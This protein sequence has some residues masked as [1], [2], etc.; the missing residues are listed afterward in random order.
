MRIADDLKVHPS[1]KGIQPEMSSVFPVIDETYESLGY[2]AW[3]TSGTEGEHNPGSL[4]PKGLAT[5][6]RTNHMREDLVPILVARLKKNLGGVRSE[7]DVVVEDDHLH[8]E[9]DP[10]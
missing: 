6:W 10:E 7:Y 4:H 5:D 2:E 3:L 1:L 9:F 8:V